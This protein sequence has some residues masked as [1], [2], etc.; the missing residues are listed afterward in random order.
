MIA[1]ERLYLAGDR[2][3]VVRE[4]DSRAQWLLCAKGHKIPDGY[5]FKEDMYE[6]DK[7]VKEIDNKA[8]YPPEQKRNRKRRGR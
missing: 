7:E 1:K 5:S 8:I 2:K 4:G 6:A 3:T